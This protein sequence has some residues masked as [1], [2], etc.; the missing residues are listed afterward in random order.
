M[1]IT[2]YGAAQTV[3]GSQ[4][5]VEVNGLRLLLDCGLYQGKRAEASERNRK[6]PFD[7]K[8]V[9]VM[10]LSHA[11]TDHAGNIPNLTKSGFRGDII[12][13]HATRDL[14]AVMLMDS[15][16]IQER[17][18]EFVNKKNRKRGKPEVEPI[19][20]TQDATASL[21]YFTSQSYNRP[22]KI[23]PGIMLTLLDAG[24]ML[25]SATVMLDIEDQTSKQTTRLVFSGDIGRK[26]IPIIRDP[27]TPDGADILIMESTYGDRTHDPYPDAEKEIER[28]INTTYRRGG[29]IIIPAFAVGRTQQVVFT[30]NQLAQRGDIP[31][32]PIYV[33]SPLAVNTTDVF[34]S[35]P[36]CFDD[37]TRDFIMG[38]N[39]R[40]DPFGFSQVTYTRSVD[41][42]KQ[43][44]FLREPA[45]IISASGMA[46]TGRILHHLKNNIEDPKTTVLIVG[47][48][49][50]DTLGRRLVDGEKVVRIFGDEYHNNAQVEVLNG[51][52]GHADSG[53]L[54]AWVEGMG[55]KP[56]RTFLVH[57]EPDAANTLAASL[58]SRLGLAVDVPAWK[59]SF[60]V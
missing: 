43:L 32:L 5:M 54:L 27:Q 39:G 44:N 45:I 49:A 31:R 21:D 51:F 57:G 23:A 22:R 28:I 42:S 6:L 12:C 1:K 58:K 18:V 11:H 10:V 30:L 41:E 48:Q 25:G 34:R 38:G 50:P 20:T 52:S 3:T 17:D 46:E 40:R 59:Q 36:E 33:D 24:H 29:K 4:H 8:S 7:A 9:D 13:T 35:H 14:C 60:E 53:E 47:W 56:R 16:H 26:G 55:R 37:E 15:A 2:F 19:Y